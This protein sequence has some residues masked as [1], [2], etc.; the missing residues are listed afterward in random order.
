MNNKELFDSMEGYEYFLRQLENI[1]E[2]DRDNYMTLFLV[3]AVNS[4]LF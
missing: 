2:N 1:P 3:L 4:L